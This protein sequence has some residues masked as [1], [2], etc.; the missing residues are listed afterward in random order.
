MWTAPA[1]ASE[2]RP[3]AT[4]AW[5]VVESQSRV[6]TMKI[7]DTLAEQGLLE[8]ALERSKPPIPADCAH[9]H[10]LL[11]TPFRY[12]PYPHASRFR[13]AR[14][15]RGCLYAAE[16][17]ETA[18]AEDA[19]YRLKFH[20]DAPTAKRPAAPQERTAF[21]FHIATLNALD[22]TQ[23]PLANDRAIWTHPTDYAPCHALADTAHEA[24]IAAL[25]Y[26]SVRDPAAR[27]NL[28]VLDCHAITTPEPTAFQTWHLM[29][30]PAQVEAICEM[31]RQR[32]VFPLAAWAATDRRIPQILP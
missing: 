4:E 22:L 1:L 14:Q 16:R 11:A 24:A 6:A 32:L 8:A 10:W 18:I 19:F 26:E 7:V 28:A 12:A 29:L 30:R 13:R 31:P 3:L 15:R 20:L 25:R 23:P 9:L 17:I 2:R 27:A 5:R 21:A